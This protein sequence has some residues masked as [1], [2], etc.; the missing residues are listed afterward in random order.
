MKAN[1]IATSNLAPFVKVIQIAVV[2]DLLDHSTRDEWEQCITY[3]RKK[4]RYLSAIFPFNVMFRSHKIQ[5]SNIAAGGP[6]AKLDL[7]SGEKAYSRYR[8]WVEGENEMREHRMDSTTPPLRLDLLTNLR[9]LQTLGH[10]R[11]MQTV[12]VNLGPELYE[13]T[14]MCTCK[15]FSTPIDKSVN[16][17]WSGARK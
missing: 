4:P 16:W 5:W 7:S 8:S 9:S 13:Q 10:Y 14:K 15:Y 3:A 12:K 1:N 17:R 6:V 11:L 2:E